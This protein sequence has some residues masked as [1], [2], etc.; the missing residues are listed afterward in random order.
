MPNAGLKTA[1]Q[2]LLWLSALA[3]VAAAAKGPAA[4]P[5]RV[6]LWGQK[7][8]R[9]PTWYGLFLDSGESTPSVDVMQYLWTGR[10]PDN[11]APSITPI[12]VNGQQAASSVTVPAGRWNDAS[13]ESRD[14]DGDAIAYR[15]LL[16]EES[17]AVSIGGDP[18]ILPP[19][20]EVEMQI[21][22]GRLRFRAPERAGAYRLFV[23]TRDGKGHA[24]YA[25]FPLQV[26][27]P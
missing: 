11:R 3:C 22:Q 7:Q 6:F 16:R 12:T 18:E 20:I 25:N 13:V 8:E 2:A 5:S 10:W 23:E 15:W 1:L 19:A 4:S 27:A 26:I 24:A 21:T 14:P 17:Q 9:T